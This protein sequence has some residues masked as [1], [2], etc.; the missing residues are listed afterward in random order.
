MNGPIEEPQLV[1]RD[2]LWRDAVLMRALAVALLLLGSE[3][4][5]AQ[6]FGLAA[7]VNGEGITRARLQSSV[8]AAMHQEG[9]NYGGITQPAQ[10][11]RRQRQALDELIARELLWQEASRQGFVAMPAEVDR[12]LEKVREDQ[13][14]LSYRN[15][16][17][18]NGFTEESYREDMKRRMSV[19]LWVQEALVK[20]IAVSDADVIDA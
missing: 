4:I 18:R 14:E 11:K 10:F 19:R 12:A 8:D 15:E 13:T 16:L 7:R 6:D 20:D 9:M 2:R 3:A 5:P 1:K 17:E